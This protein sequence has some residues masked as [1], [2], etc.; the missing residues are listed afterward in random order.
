MPQT[1]M[2]VTHGFLFLFSPLFG[3]PHLNSA[4]GGALVV[5]V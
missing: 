3:T 2:D 4:L 1:I 5:Y